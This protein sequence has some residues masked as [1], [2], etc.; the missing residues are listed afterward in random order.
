MLLCFMRSCGF[1]AKALLDK[2]TREQHSFFVLEAGV[3]F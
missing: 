1:A 2:K 3:Y